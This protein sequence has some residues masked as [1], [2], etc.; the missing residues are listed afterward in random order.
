MK[1]T[2]SL[3]LAL[4]VVLSLLAGCATT[5]PSNP[6]GTNPS[7][8]AVNY[9]P[10]DP[11]DA[12]EHADHTSVY[13]TIGAYITIDMVE[14]DLDTGLAYVQYEGTKYELGMDFLSYAMV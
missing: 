10:V 6:G 5:N 3:A 8:P 12:V 11:A 4:C 13:D 9:Q 2:L 7:Q 14:E 1:R